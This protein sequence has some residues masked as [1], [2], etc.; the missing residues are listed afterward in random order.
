MKEKIS[1]IEKVSQPSRRKFFSENE[2]FDFMSD[3]EKFSQGFQ[4]QLNTIIPNETEPYT[5]TRLDNSI[6]HSRIISH[7]ESPLE[8]Q[9]SFETGV[10]DLD[11]L[12]R[13]FI[14]TDFNNNLIYGSGVLL[15][16]PLNRMWGASG[17]SEYSLT[18]LPAKDYGLFSALSEVSGYG[19]FI[20]NKEIAKDKFYVSSEVRQE[21]EELAQTWYSKT[22]YLSVLKEKINNSYYRQIIGM[23]DKIIPILLEKLQRNPQHWFTALAD[24][25]RK[26]NPIKDEDKGNVQRMVE[27]WLNW[28]KQNSYIG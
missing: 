2:M 19:N 20:A 7:V 15:G 17:E 13:L 10:F 22:K 3:Y 4:E 21:F 28:G 24:I 23:G 8:G 12:S 1:P 11:D 25:A 26:R 9:A 16:D 5:Y 18:L 14:N 27:A 6:F